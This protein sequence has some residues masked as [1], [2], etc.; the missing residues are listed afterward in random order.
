M[1]GCP[2]AVSR[3]HGHC[4]LS[5]PVWTMVL[6]MLVTEHNCVSCQRTILDQIDILDHLWFI[7][8]ESTVRGISF[9]LSLWPRNLTCVR[10]SMCAFI[11][12]HK[13]LL[14]EVGLVA[15]RL[16]ICGFILL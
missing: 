12:V 1:S 5:C 7:T 9:M 16:C 8:T 3:W 14:K 11:T 13:L 6:A 15:F 2:R 10:F 4:A